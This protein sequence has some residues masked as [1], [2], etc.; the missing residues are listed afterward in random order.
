MFASVIDD[1]L[2]EIF[3]E[4][5]ETKITLSLEF[6]DLSSISLPSLTLCDQPG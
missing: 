4:S 5:G 1:A 6:F 3:L 2:I